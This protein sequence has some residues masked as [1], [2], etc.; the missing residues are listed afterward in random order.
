MALTKEKIA[1]WI[2]D[3]FSNDY[4]RFDLICSPVEIIDFK[5]EGNVLEV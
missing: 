5:Q 1:K 4:F 3:R 2:E